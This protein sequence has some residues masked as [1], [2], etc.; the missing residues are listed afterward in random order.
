MGLKPYIIA[1]A[2]D[3]IVAQ[4]LVRRICPHCKAE[5]E[6]T[7]NEAKVIDVMMEDI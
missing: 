4:R 2:L 7:A 6:K 1:S 3:T 5:I